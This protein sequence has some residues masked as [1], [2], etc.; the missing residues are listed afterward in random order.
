MEVFEKEFEEA[1]DGRYDVQLFPDAQ[2]GSENEVAEG[3]AMGSVTM[4]L[5]SGTNISTWDNK[6]SMFEL[7][8]LF[9]DWDDANAA[10]DSELG[11]IYNTWTEE[12]GVHCLG[13]YASGFRATWNNIRP[14]RSPE[15][16][17]GLKL[18]VINSDMFINLF[19][20]LGAN[21]TPMNWN[22]IYTGLEQGTIDGQDNP[23][24][25]TYD[26]KFYEK[27]KYMTATN[28]VCLSVFAAVNNDF[29]QGLSDEDRAAFDKAADDM[30]AYA[31]ENCKKADAEALEKCK[32]AGVECVELTEEEMQAFKDCVQ[33]I[34]DEYRDIVGSDV[35]DKLL[36]R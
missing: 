36:S 30:L 17:K 3:I 7:P 22:E 25:L 32:A 23:P 4:E 5:L 15:D 6:F 18:R 2:L 19:S 8:F 26:A 11:E 16:M 14:V 34:Y 1:T 33:P 27:L 24:I 13:F 29:Y 35:M 20:L 28:H 12:Y 9:S 21:P 10:Y 31:R